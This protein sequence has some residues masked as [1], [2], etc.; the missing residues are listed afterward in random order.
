MIIQFWRR[1]NKIPTTSVTGLSLGFMGTG[2]LTDRSP[3]QQAHSYWS[4]CCS[5]RT[6]QSE[7][8]RIS[9]GRFKGVSRG[10]RF[11]DQCAHPKQWSVPYDDCSHHSA[12]CWSPPAI[13][14]KNL[15]GWPPN[16]FKYSAIFSRQVPTAKLLSM[17][18]LPKF[19][20]FVI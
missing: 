3:H 6:N 17:Q 12:L 13:R 11:R 5:V 14:N 4:P 2:W 8:N 15:T 7:W 10:T 16:T 1:E 18:M 20:C 19:L 9:S